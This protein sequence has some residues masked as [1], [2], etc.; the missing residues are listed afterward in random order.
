MKVIDAFFQGKK[1]S[2]LITE[3]VGAPSERVLNDLRENNKEYEKIITT[4]FE[5]IGEALGTLCFMDVRFLN[6]FSRYFKAYKNL[7]I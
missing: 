3:Y 1:Y 7:D 2:D 5:G 6:P 4:D